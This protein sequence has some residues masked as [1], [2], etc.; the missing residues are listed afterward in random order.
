MKHLGSAAALGGAFTLLSLC[1]AFTTPPGGA[2]DEWAHYLRTI[3]VSRGQWLGQ[4]ASGYDD[5]ALSPAQ[6]R[7]VMQAARAVDIPPGLG[8]GSLG[9]HAF[10][11][12]KSAACNDSGPAPPQAWSVQVTPTGTYQP[13]PYGPLALAAR[14]ASSPKVALLAGRTAMALW[15]GLLLWLAAAALSS[16]LARLG[17]LF[18]CT[19]LAFFLAGSLNPSGLE[20]AAAV[21][22]FAGASGVTG[23]T[24]SR[25]AAFA[26]LAVGGFW[27]PVS[28]S[29]GAPYLLVLLVL[30][31]L[32]SGLAAWRRAA[33]EGSRALS[34]AALCAVTGVAFNRWWETAYGPKVQ[35]QFQALAPA[36]GAAARKLPG[37]VKQE[38]GVF[39]YLDTPMPTWAYATWGL[40]TVALLT[41]GW[42]NG[43]RRRRANV[44]LAIGAAL[45][46]PVALDVLLMR[47]TGWQVQGRHVLPLAAPLM[48]IATTPNGG[49]V[50][51]RWFKPAKGLVVLW[52]AV[53][54]A[55]LYASGHRAAVGLAA[56]WRWGQSEWSP[57]L[58][59]PFW[60]GVGTAAVGLAAASTLRVLRADSDVPH[61]ATAEALP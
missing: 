22:F 41:I 37:W 26:A 15:C 47:F 36:V 55:G 10:S 52:A 33:K 28:R 60:L 42:L 40:G 23:P 27:L 2:P 32:S 31:M 24:R 4:Q 59:W 50:V 6:H 9:C 35:L 5:P 7:W 38:V 49:Q 11:L 48:L 25:R 29:M 46:V 12:E 30:A 1:W 54:L 51:T 34:L 18:A 14:C 43:D 45:G 39:G 58:G 16:A 19:P 8:F 56:P 21:C 20:V 57:L 17:L 53:Q 3:A 13:L 44:A 61:S